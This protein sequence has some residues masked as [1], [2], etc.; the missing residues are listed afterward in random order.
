MKTKRYGNILLIVAFIVLG[1]AQGGYATICDSDPDAVPYTPTVDP[2]LLNGVLNMLG[3]IPILIDVDRNINLLYDHT[4]V[5]TMESNINLAGVDFLVTPGNGSIEVELSLPAW[6]AEMNIAMTHAPCRDCN[7]E[8]NSCTG[9]C[10][11]DQDNC[12]NDCTSSSDFPCFGSRFCCENIECGPEWVV[13]EG[14]CAAATAVCEVSYLACF[15][16][17]EG[18]DLLLDGT[19][20]GLSYDSA[21]VSQVADVCVTGECEAVHPLESTDAAFSGFYLQLFSEGDSLGIGAWINGIISGMVNWLVDLLDLVEKFFVN[22]D[23]EGMLINTFSK[24]IKQDGCAPAPAVKECRGGACSIS[25][26]PDVSARQGGSLL[27]YSLPI[28]VTTGLILWRR[29]R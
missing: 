26:K 29:R 7:A 1:T 16:E 14:L 5:L 19:S 23:G 4:M 21:T 27:L 24:D 6:G 9:D 28:L 25:T 22:S 15:A 2:S 11:D 17:K 20:A 3:E 18:I 8:N 13:C 10:D 12:V